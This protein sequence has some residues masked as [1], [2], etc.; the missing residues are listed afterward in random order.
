M[1][2]NVFLKKNVLKCIWVKKCMDICHL[3]PATLNQVITDNVEVVDIGL[4]RP[5]RLTQVIA[6]VVDI[7]QL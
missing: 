7:G 5:V 1:K 3:R 2:T 6:D 4:L